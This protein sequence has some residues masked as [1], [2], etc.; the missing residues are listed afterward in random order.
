[1]NTAALLEKHTPGKQFDIIGCSGYSN[2]NNIV[3]LTAS[4][5]NNF[6]EEGIVQGTLLFVDKDSTYEKG[7]LNVF[8]YKRD[9]SPQYKLSRTKIPNGSFIGTVFM[10]VNQY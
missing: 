3:C 2:M 5:D 9:R 1:M 7:K 6:I 10:A 4:A 8:R